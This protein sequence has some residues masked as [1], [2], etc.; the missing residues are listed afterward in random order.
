MLLL[1]L[2]TPLPHSLQQGDERALL[3]QGLVA[4]AMGAL[5]L[6]SA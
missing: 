2:I 5:A 3:H 6:G 1:L 4:S